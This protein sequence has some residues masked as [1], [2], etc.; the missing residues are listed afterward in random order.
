MSTRALWAGE[1]VRHPYGAA[2][3]PLV[4]AISFGYKTVDE[5]KDVALGHAPGT[6]L[7]PQYKPD[8]RRAGREDARSGRCRGS[9]QLFLWH[10]S[11]QQHSAC[12]AA[13][14]RP[15]GECDGHLRWNKPYLHGVSATHRGRGCAGADARRSSDPGGDCKRMYRVVPG[16]AHESDAKDSGPVQAKRDRQGSRSHGHHRQHGLQLL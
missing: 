7:L 4:P 6:H 8:A 10:G 14:G 3:M 11:H 1:D 2:Q 12:A 13:G 15:R 9:H 16:D 5:W